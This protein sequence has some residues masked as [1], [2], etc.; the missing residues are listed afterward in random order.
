MRTTNPR[1]AGLAALGVTAVLLAGCTQLTGKANVN[2]NANENANVNQAAVQKSI[3]VTLATQNNSGEQGTAEL[4]SENGKT[5]VE[6]SVSGAPANVAQPA[7]IH[8]NSCANIGAVKYPLTNVVN[9][10]SETVVDVSLDD[11]LNMLPLSINVHKSAAEAGV[12]VACGNITNDS[13][14]MMDGNTNAAVNTNTDAGVNINANNNVNAGGSMTKGE[15]KSFTVE[16]ANFSFSL[17]EIKVKKGDTV[18]IKLVNKEGFHDLNI[19]E[20]GVA[21]PK[22]NGEGQTADIEFVAGKTGIFEYYCSVGQ[23]RAMGMV[24]KLIVE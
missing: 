15:T 10:K 7:H 23:H 12:Y 2:T 17:K 13:G 24:G 22:L 20:F 8:L 11:L 6:I 5:K 9:G 18:K 1:R 14:A 4:K 16:T 3:T 19:D 21:T